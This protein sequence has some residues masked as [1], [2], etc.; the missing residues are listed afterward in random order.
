MYAVLQSQLPNLLKH[1]TGP[2]SYISF[3]EARGNCPNLPRHFRAL[4][5]SAHRIRG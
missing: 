1:T 5:D 3:A 2:G 4:G